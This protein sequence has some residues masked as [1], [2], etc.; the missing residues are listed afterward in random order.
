MQENTKKHLNHNSMFILLIIVLCITGLVVLAATWIGFRNYIDG[1][2]AIRGAL[3]WLDDFPYLGTTHWELRHPF[4]LSVASSILMFG[5]NE[6]SVLA[7]NVVAYLVIIIITMSIFHIYGHT[8]LGLLTS[9]IFLSVP[10][11]SFSATTIFPGIIELL[12]VISSLVIF[13]LSISREKPGWIPFFLAGLLGGFAFT[14][15]ETSI[16]FGN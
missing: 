13:L 4:I 11:F 7:P 16:R 10:V 1:V 5:T 3:L 12:L 15:R 8:A 6:I 2:F 14:T 9:L